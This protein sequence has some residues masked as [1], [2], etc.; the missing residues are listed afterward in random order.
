MKPGERIDVVRRSYEAVAERD[1]E[2]LFAL[3][4]EDGEWD[5]RAAAFDESVYHGHAG[6]RRYLEGV[7]SVVTDFRIDI[8]DAHEVGDLVVAA[9]RVHATGLESGIAAERP[10]GAVWTV[11]DGRI[12]SL[13]LYPTPEEARAAAGLD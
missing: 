8:E 7:W 12:A 1:L 2:T 4:A 10:Y 3:L 6:I 13:H 9:V 11:R 5:L